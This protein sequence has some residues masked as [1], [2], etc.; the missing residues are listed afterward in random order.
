[1]KTKLIQSIFLYLTAFVGVVM[2]A[3]G[4]TGLI[5]LSIKTLVFDIREPEYS[6]VERCDDTRYVNG[7]EIER[8]EEDIA[9]CQKNAKIEDQRRWKMETAETIS[10]SVALLLIGS[11][12]WFWAYRRGKKID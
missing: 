1:M 3:I 8:T 11:P 4:G 9:K 10:E 6:R 12:I 2:I 7:N 5:N